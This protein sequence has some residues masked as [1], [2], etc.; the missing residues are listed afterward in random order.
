[1]LI[2]AGAS[3]ALLCAYPAGRKPAT[4]AG[5]H[6]ITDRGAV[7]TYL[8]GRPTERQEAVACNAA[9]PTGYSIVF[10][11]ANRRPAVVHNRGCAWDQGGS[12]RYGGDLA[13]VTGFW[14]V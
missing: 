8:N 11:Y 6:G 14:A 4:H 13:I 5:I 12:V 3:M 9:S 2:P 7:T 10:E 1:M